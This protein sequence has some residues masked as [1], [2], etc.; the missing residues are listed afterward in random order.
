MYIIR[1]QNCAFFGRHGVWDE[2]HSLGQRFFVDAVLSVD[3]PV[4]LQNDDIA[5]TVNYGDVFNVIHNFMTAERF[6]LIEALAYAIGQKLL[7]AFPPVRRVEIT[8]RKPSVPIPGILDG[9]AV[10]VTLP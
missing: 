7:A 9:T 10:T 5:E 3:A 2:E 6:N 8:V 4:A 1:L